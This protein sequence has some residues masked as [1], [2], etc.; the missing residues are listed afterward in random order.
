MFEL[1]RTFQS[2]A[3]PRSV[4]V[5]LAAVVAALTFGCT[6]SSRI[7]DPLPPPPG[8]TVQGH[9]VSLAN[10]SFGLGLLT[11]VLEEETEPNVLLSTLSASMAL[12]MTLNGAVGETYDAMRGALGFGTLSEDEVNAAYR[13]L[14]DHL[15]GL[16]PDVGFGL[17]N[18][19]WHEE[20]FPVKAPFLDAARIHFD[21]EVRALDFSDPGAPGVIS[22]WA[23]EKTGGR[24]KDLVTKIDPDEM[25]FLVNAVYF[26]AP[27]ALPFN[28][29]G[30]QA[31]A[32]R[33]LAG[34]EATVP[35]MTLDGPV[36]HSSDD[37]IQAVELL[38]A[39]S[40]YAMLVV[41]PAEG[42]TLDDVEDALTPTG[43]AAIVESLSSSRILL[44]LP[45]FR[46]EYDI[47]LD[48]ALTALG[49]GIAFDPWQSN[50]TRIADRDD[51]YITRVEQKAFIDVHELGTEA[52][53]AT[54]VGV[55]ITSLPPQL[56]F[57]RPF[58][59]LIRERAGGAILFLGRVGDPS[60]N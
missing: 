30:T 39:D 7:T 56:T 24:I 32:F 18:S 6:Q 41:G 1:T 46:F 25:L 60:L 42:G 55:G 53:A 10:T 57:G 40:A 31:G 15:R 9:Q 27:W 48:P 21:A 5:A 47:R 19:A 16:D 20:S 14:I 52:S 37:R 4:R 45:K 49:M 58:Y 59:F 22:G 33:T 43:L 17:A 29:F 50:F 3:A 44:T 11:R 54:S 13:N 36:L 34:A 8:L 51:L 28:E 38:Y 2:A 35:L 26:K 12:G 23:E